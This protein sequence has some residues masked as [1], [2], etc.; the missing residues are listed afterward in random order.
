MN[1]IDL[2]QAIKQA[3]TKPKLDALRMDCVLIGK[4]F[5]SEVFTE[6]QKAFIKQNNKLRRIPMKDRTW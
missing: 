3:D 1:K 2:L 6:V 5:G 4:E